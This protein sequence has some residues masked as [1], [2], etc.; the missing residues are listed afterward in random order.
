MQTY[1]SASKQIINKGLRSID[2]ADSFRMSV[3][4]VL[5]IVYLLNTIFIPYDNF[6]LKKLSFVLLIILNIDKLFY[7]LK[8][9]S[10]NYTVLFVGFVLPVYTI[11][12]SIVVT[13][14]VVGNILA[15]YSGLIL[16]LFCV[17]EE[18]RDFFLSAMIKILFLLVLLIDASV[19]L[20]RLGIMSVFSNPILAWMYATS[21]ADIGK[22]GA[23]LLGYYIFIKTSPMM[24]LCLGHFAEEKRYVLSFATLLALCLSGTRANS[25]LGLMTFAVVFIVTEKDRTKKAL[26]IGAIIAAGLYVLFGRGFLEKYMTYAAS[27]SSGDMVRTRTLTSIIG[28]WKK[29]PV[30]FIVGQGYTSSFYNLGRTEYT[31]DVELSYWNLL[32]RVGILSFTMFMFGYLYPVFTLLKKEKHIALCV[33]LLSYLVGAYINPFLYTSTGITVLLWMCLV[34][35]AGADESS[36]Y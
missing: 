30:S 34:A 17:V 10:N 2:P 6:S 36:K 19:V 9:E 22:G 11:I 35:F 25:L 14:N 15:G 7:F 21:N 20:D 29:D 5:E 24:L 13:G 27:K 1:Y 33:C 3:N 28:T 12:T 18:D 16:L 26:V 31:S 4:R 8:K 32:R 23:F